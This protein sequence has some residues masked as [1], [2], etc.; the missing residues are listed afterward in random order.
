[1]IGFVTGFGIE[2]PRSAYDLLDSLEREICDF[3][4]DTKSRKKW[5]STIVVNLIVINPTRGVIPNSVSVKRLSREL[6]SSWNLDFVSFVEADEEGRMAM[7]RQATCKALE[8]LEGK[9]LDAADIEMMVARI[10]NG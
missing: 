6:W 8:A 9:H 1:M 2:V 5:L 4:R 3:D 10:S 7:L